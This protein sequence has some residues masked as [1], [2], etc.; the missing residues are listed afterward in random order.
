MRSSR[1]CARGGATLAESSVLDE[2]RNIFDTMVAEKHFEKH[3]VTSQEQDLEGY[4]YGMKV[5]AD[6]IRLYTDFAAKETLPG[7]KAVLLRIA[8][9]EKKHYNFLENIYEFVL[10]PQY[11]LQ[12][13]EFTNADEML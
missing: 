1:S 6:S 10:K 3:A 8:E 12:W 4:L 13:R 11:F 9:E 7:P 5:E 2:A